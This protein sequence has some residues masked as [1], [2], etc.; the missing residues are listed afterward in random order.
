M[1]ILFTSLSSSRAAGVRSLPGRL[2]SLR[3]RQVAGEV[4]MRP[5]TWTAGRLGHELVATEFRD[6]ASPAIGE[7]AI[8]DAER[9]RG[10]ASATRRRSAACSFLLNSKASVSMPE[11]SVAAI[12]SGP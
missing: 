12:T 11:N 4:G 8:S 9:T 5:G 1:L 6:G 10:I 2:Y 7:K 3:C